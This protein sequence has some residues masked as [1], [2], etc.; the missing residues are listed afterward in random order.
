MPVNGILRETSKFRE[1]LRKTFPHQFDQELESYDPSKSYACLIEGTLI[2]A[3]RYGEQIATLSE[4]K[5][6]FVD[7]DIDVI[8]VVP[9]EEQKRVL[10]EF[11]RH[12]SGWTYLGNRGDGI[13]K[14]E[15][16]LRLPTS[17][18]QA[19]EGEN[20]LFADI[21]FA[22]PKK[23]GGDGSVR[24]QTVPAWVFK[25]NV[26]ADGLMDPSTLFPMQK[27]HWGQ[28]E[29]YFAPNEYT[30]LL[31]TWDGGEYTS[32]PWLPQADHLATGDW[33]ACSCNV[34]E[35]DMKKIRSTTGSL[36]KRGFA[37]FHDRFVRRRAGR[38]SG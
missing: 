28:G 13:H 32:T 20:Q 22:M 27:V 25:S 1:A 19:A 18:D 16:T 17:C 11:G 23:G 10:E 8:F 37:N 24:L 9:E 14:F 30:H 15:S 34:D 38:F 3:A 7:G 33:F 31:Q 5:L 12:L 26:G 2:G 36:Q 6:N 29:G 4:G 35:R 21:H